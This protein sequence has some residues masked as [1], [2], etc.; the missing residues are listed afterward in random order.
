MPPLGDVLQS[1]FSVFADE[2]DY[3]ISLT[4][5]YLLSGLSFP[6]WMPTS[7]LEILPILGGV[8]TIGIGDSAASIV[9]TRW[10]KTKWPGSSKTVE[11]TVACI[12]SQLI[13]VYGLAALGFIPNYFGIVRSTLSIIAV[14]FIEARTDQVDN[15]TLPIILY[16]CLVI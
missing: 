15:L 8:L 9:G 11:G 1:G 5:L 12:L 16:T 10:G 6:L 3:L 4:P 2:K 13:F 14:S 7:N